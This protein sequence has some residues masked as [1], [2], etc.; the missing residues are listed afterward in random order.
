[1]FLRHFARLVGCALSAAA[2][3]VAFPAHAEIAPERPVIIRQTTS[4]EITIPEGTLDPTT[5]IR[6]IEQLY[7]PTRYT[8]TPDATIITLP[9]VAALPMDPSPPADSSGS[10]VEIPVAD[11]LPRSDDSPAAPDPLGA[12]ASTEMQTTVSAEE[13]PLLVAPGSLRINEILPNPIEGETEWV[14]IYNPY[15]NLILTRGM[16]LTDASNKRVEFPDVMV[17]FDQYALVEVPGSILNNSGDRVVLHAANG[18]VIDSA[19]YSGTFQKGETA[20]WSVDGWKKTSAASP[21]LPNTFPPPPPPREPEVASTPA[22][23]IPE[24]TGSPPP[25]SEISLTQASIPET[26]L[27]VTL[28]LGELYPRPHGADEEEEYV[29][30]VNTG[31]AP[32]EL[33]G[34]SLADAG[35]K[36]WKAEGTHVVAAHAEVQLPRPLTKIT[37]NNDTD[38][39]TLVHPNGIPIDSVTYKDAPKGGRY[40]KE[41]ETWRWQGQMAALAPSGE[42]PSPPPLE[43]PPVSLTPTPDTPEIAV[44]S[45]VKVKKSSTSRTEIIEAIVSAL[46][47]AFST[48]QFY[49]QNPDTQVYMQKADFPELALGDRVRMQGTFGEAYGQKRFKVSAREHI[50]ILGHE[51][52]PVATVL[53]LGE[54]GDKHVGALLKTEGEVVEAASERVRLQE[55]THE[56]IVSAKRPTGINFTSLSPG[57]KVTITGI[58]VLSNGTRQL[59]PRTQEDIVLEQ[60]AEEPAASGLVLA[61]REPPRWLWSFAV[62]TFGMLLLLGWFLRSRRLK[63]LTLQTS[64]GN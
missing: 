26:P 25:P 5:L 2:T 48:Q 64:Y 55:G 13:P 51:E 60:P 12:P 19:A 29:T 6:L 18:D 44:A 59:L 43:I 56:L 46:P 23:V 52:P 17:G 39:I 58:L 21:R 42:A 27:A 57:E 20:G 28:R 63:H 37:L 45:S 16:Y 7:G 61:V 62:F 8:Q 30:I 41:G 31:D 22:L 24:I 1:M 15:N 9:A 34:W 53:P 54:I 38:T 3:F 33:Y 32:A 10:A 47:G 14:E 36:V 35:G 49:V 11:P 50:T 4:V 40:R